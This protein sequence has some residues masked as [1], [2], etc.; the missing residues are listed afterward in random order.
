M[1][2]VRVGLFGEVLQ[3]RFDARRVPEETFSFR[4]AK[5]GQAVQATAIEK[6]RSCDRRTPL[7]IGRL[8]AD[9]GGSKGPLSEARIGGTRGSHQ[10]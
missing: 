5:K 9:M 2:F 10:S 1:K 6:R 3:V 7:N 4:G 8:R